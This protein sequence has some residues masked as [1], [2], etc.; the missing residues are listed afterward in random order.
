MRVVIRQ[1]VPGQTTADLPDGDGL[2]GQ[3]RAVDALD[4]GARIDRHGYNIFALCDPQSGAME[5]IRQYLRA[6]ARRG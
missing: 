3:S 2:L 1:L 6:I 5:S 4:F